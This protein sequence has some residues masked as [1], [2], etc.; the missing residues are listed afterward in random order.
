MPKVMDA[1]A[2]LPRRLADTKLPY[3]FQEDGGEPRLPITIAPEIDKKWRVRRRRP[4]RPAAL[5]Q[6]NLKLP[7]HG[8]GQRNIASFFELGLAHYQHASFEVNIRQRKF[9]GFT[10]PQTRGVE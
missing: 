9:Q 5:L 3:D 2:A 10:N 4:I 6:I 7:R 8:V 1:W